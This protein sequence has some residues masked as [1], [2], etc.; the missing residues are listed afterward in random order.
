MR[1]IQKTGITAV[2]T[3]TILLLSS[4]ERARETIDRIRETYSR[5]QAELAVAALPP[6]PV[7]A[8]NTTHAI[9]GPIQDYLALTG[10]IIAASTVDAFSE[11][12]GRVSRVHVSVG[13][14]VRRGDPLV[15]VDPSRPGME[16]VHSIVRAPVAGTIVALPAQLGMTISPA[17]PLARVSGGTGLEIR[18]FVAERFISRISL[19]QPCEITL[20]AWPGRVF[21]GAVREISPIVDV[22]SRTMEIR[23]SVH[24]PG[25]ILKPGM[26]ARVHIITEERDNIVKIPVSA[27]VSRFGERHI[28]VADTSDPEAPVAQRRTIV[29]GIIIDGV[30]EVAY[31]L[32][33]GEEV[34]IRGQSL[35]ED[36]SRIN[37]VERLAPL[38]ARPQS[39]N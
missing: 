7:F 28:F 22:A 16:F 11:V 5:V 25:A 17:V 32:A 2:L 23:V 24:D 29:P 6:P 37:I 14:R 34:V 18:L 3:I 15:S 8:V 19:N 20:D 38:A 13:S 39:A 33:P 10:D 30:M 35:L 9:Q 31:G 36:G 1:L 21:R 26:F 4:C 12:A 27:V